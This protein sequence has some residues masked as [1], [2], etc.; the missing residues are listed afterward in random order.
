MDRILDN[1]AVSAYMKCPRMYLNSMVRHRRR[2]FGK[3]ALSY[4]K[5]IHKG[6]EILYKTHDLDLAIAVMQQQYSEALPDDGSDYRTISR[7]TLTMEKWIEYWGH[8]AASNEHTVGYPATPAVELSTNVVL[9]LVNL[10]YAVRIDR[11][12]EM[13]GGFY[14]EDHKTSSQF[15]ATFYNE[16][17]LSGQMKG[18]A[19][20]AELLIGKPIRGV[21]INAVVT[22]KRDEEF[23]RRILYFT[24]GVLENWELTHKMWHDRIQRS[25]AENDWP[26]SWAACSSKYGMCTYSEICSLDPAYEEQALATDFDIFPWDPN[27]QHDD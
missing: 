11:I 13:D 5:A 20:A 14:I 27:A 15:G 12:F 7:A 18:Y 8:P 9:P 24:P 10:P 4:G 19:R 22:R 2:D 21:R 26:Q 16:F 6:F 1:T 23:D 3:A 17:E 25:H